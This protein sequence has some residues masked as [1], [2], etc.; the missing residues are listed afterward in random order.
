MT[1]LRSSFSMSASDI[2]PVIISFMR[3]FVPPRDRGAS[4]LIGTY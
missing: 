2:V 4:V 3:I 1:A